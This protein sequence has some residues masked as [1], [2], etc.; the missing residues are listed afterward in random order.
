[1]RL[2]QYYLNICKMFLNFFR[3]R[4]Y[5]LFKNFLNL[6]I[7]KKNNCLKKYA[8]SVSLEITQIAIIF[9]FDF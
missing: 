6:F 2:A 4:F 1:M 3:R 7:F 9:I 8:L 5:F